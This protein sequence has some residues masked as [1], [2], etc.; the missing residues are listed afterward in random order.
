MSLHQIV[1]AEGSVVDPAPSSFREV[2]VPGVL[3]RHRGA[4][5]TRDVCGCAAAPAGAGRRRITNEL[6]A[7]AAGGG[8]HPQLAA[9]RGD[10][11]LAVRCPDR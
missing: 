3:R 10:D 5:L 1:V 2:D 9:A 6:H 11:V 8:E 7:R 4:L